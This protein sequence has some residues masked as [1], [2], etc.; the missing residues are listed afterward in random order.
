MNHLRFVA[1]HTQK[2]TA[3]SR[4]ALP[5][6]PDCRHGAWHFVTPGNHHWGTAVFQPVTT[7]A[8]L[9]KAIRPGGAAQGRPRHRSQFFTTHSASS[10]TDWSIDHFWFISETAHPPV[11]RVIT[12]DMLN[13]GF[14]KSICTTAGY[15]LSINSLPAGSPDNWCSNELFTGIQNKRYVFRSS[16]FLSISLFPISDCH[17]AL[18]TRQNYVRVV[19]ARLWGTLPSQQTIPRTY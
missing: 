10:F 19:L 7:N 17:T 16:T 14:T 15:Y 3:Y 13:P 4:V 8:Y 2:A 6:Y 9:P 18:L 5:V 11:A 1:R 12:L